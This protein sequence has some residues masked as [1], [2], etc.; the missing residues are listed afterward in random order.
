MPL[1]EQAVLL[2]R[3]LGVRITAGGRRRPASAHGEI[4]KPRE[5]DG[6]GIGIGLGRELLQDPQS[7]F[8]PRVGDDGFIEAGVVVGEEGA[9]RRW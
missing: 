8:T 2:V 4:V 6:Q 3:P 9:Q 7:E 1:V 5:L